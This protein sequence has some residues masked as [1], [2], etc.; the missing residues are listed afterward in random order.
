MK[1]PLCS[2]YS[3]GRADSEISRKLGAARADLQQLAAVWKQANVPVKDKLQY[4]HSLIISRLIYGLASMWLMVGQRRRLDGFYARCLRS[5][6]RV[7]HSFISR[8][9]NAQVFC[10]AGVSKF[11]DQLLQRQMILLGKVA[12]SPADSPLRRDTFIPGTILPQLGRFVG[13]VGRPRQDWTRELL[14]IGTDKLGAAK[15]DRMLSDTASGAQ[16]RWKSEW[17]RVLPSRVQ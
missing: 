8:V 7:P 10:K 9:S 5:I 1:R 3:D 17:Q 4:F 11:S 16:L 13:R 15:F 6:L 2:V 12:R 14:K